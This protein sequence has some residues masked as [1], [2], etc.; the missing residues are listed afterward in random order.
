MRIAAAL[1]AF[2]VGWFACV[3]AG[4]WEAPALALLVVPVIGLR[5]VMSPAPRREIMLVAAVTGIGLV[6]DGALTRL[7][8]LSFGADARAVPP[9]WFV[10]FWPNFATI[11]VEP[12]RFLRGRRIVGALL[13]AISGP[14]A[15]LG[16]AKLG[17]LEVDA[18]WPI[19]AEW[20]VLVPVLVGLA[21]RLFPGRPTHQEDRGAATETLG[22]EPC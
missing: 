8:V 7:G 11:L 9:V 15:Y 21:A 19:A 13:G 4:A 20:G 14:L 18:I 6:M 10:A 3:F 1:I 2:H 16:G 5:M 12:L 17:A 22:G